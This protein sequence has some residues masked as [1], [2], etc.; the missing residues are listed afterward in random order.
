MDHPG[1][2]G[3]RYNII[4]GNGSEAFIISS[5]GAISNIIITD[6]ET[7]VS[8]TLI[9]EA[10]VIDIPGIM[11]ARAN[12]SINVVDVNDEVPVFNQSI[13]RVNFIASVAAHSSIITVFAYDEDIGSN[14]RITYKISDG[15]PLFQMNS[16]TGEIQNTES[17]SLESA[18]I[19]HVEASDQ[20]T[21]SN[22]AT[23]VVL[24]S[25]ALPTIAELNFSQ[26][27]YEL[28]VSED[29]SLG[30]SL[31]FITITHHDG[32]AI[33]NVLIL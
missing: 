24:V 28:N 29:A 26:P 8:Y 31:G 1:I 21:P 30:T 11:P 2:K 9:I 19:L 22:T 33:E 7:T 18:Y 3:I 15:D 10:T 12:A 13:Y 4:V 16:T 25:I 23:T 17:L 14:A 32:S 6:R 5:I 27:S 20:G